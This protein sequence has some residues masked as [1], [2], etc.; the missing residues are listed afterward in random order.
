MMTSTKCST[1]VVAAPT[2][3]RFG[4]NGTMR[5]NR[6]VPM[7]LSLVVAAAAAAVNNITFGSLCLS[8]RNPTG[9]IGLFLS[10]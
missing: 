2:T 8:R 6:H 4:D 1:A 10:L 5:S 3:G 9:L 7:Y